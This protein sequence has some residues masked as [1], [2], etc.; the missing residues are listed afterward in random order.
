MYRFCWKLYTVELVA[1][2]VCAWVQYVPAKTR[3]SL[4]TL[5]GAFAL[6]ALVGSL[7]A[8]KVASPHLISLFSLRF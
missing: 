3:S 2:C 8:H 5:R 7:L 1:V 6:R 4:R